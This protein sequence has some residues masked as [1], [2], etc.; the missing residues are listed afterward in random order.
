MRS[1]IEEDLEGIVLSCVMKEADK[2][3]GL[4]RRLWDGCLRRMKLM[5]AETLLGACFFVIH[6]ACM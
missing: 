2:A 6:F 3:V 4:E 1:W 5:E